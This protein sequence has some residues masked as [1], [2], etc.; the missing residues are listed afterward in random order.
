MENPQKE[1]DNLCSKTAV[2]VFSIVRGHSQIFFVL[3]T[4]L[5]PAPRSPSANTE[6]K[7]TRKFIT[8]CEPMAPQAFGIR[9]AKGGKSVELA[10]TSSMAGATPSTL[11]VPA[12][13]RPSR[14]DA[15]ARA[16]AKDKVAGRPA[17]GEGRG[18]CCLRGGWCGT[19]TAKRAS[20]WARVAASPL[21]L[22]LTRLLQRSPNH[23][24]RCQGPSSGL[25]WQRPDPQSFFLGVHVLPRMRTCC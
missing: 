21:H 6:V 22:P 5:H 24:P 3:R 10:G 1:E 19:G 23:Q 14:L 20:R 16:A 12:G 13:G 9:L 8:R 7:G 2:I 15:N 25:K 11:L 17:E 4:F 18:A